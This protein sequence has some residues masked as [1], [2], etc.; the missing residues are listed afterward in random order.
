[1]I[2]QH[3]VRG[4]PVQPGVNHHHKK[5]DA[6]LHGASQVIIATMAAMGWLLQAMVPVWPT[7]SGH[8]IT[9]KASQTPSLTLALSVTLCTC[10]AVQECTL[11][12]VW[13]A[14]QMEPRYLIQC[15]VRSLMPHVHTR[16]C[17][18]EVSHPELRGR[19]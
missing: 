16:A 1:M 11:P 19:K 18:R 9:V 6:V 10:I 7:P 17:N 3:Q 4:D 15:K 13:N 2:F 14:V 8:N 12:C 5:L